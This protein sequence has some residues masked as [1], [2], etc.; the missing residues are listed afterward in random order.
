VKSVDFATIVDTFPTIHRLGNTDQFGCNDCN[1][2]G[3]KWFM[4]EHKCRRSESKS[5]VAEAAAN[6]SGDG[7]MFGDKKESDTDP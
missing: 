2:R 7:L 4:Q 3:D 1:L 6:V 5:K